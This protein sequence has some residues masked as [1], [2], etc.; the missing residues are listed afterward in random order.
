MRTF[1]IG[2]RI[3][4]AYADYQFSKGKKLGKKGRKK[5][6]TA[7]G[8]KTVVERN[9]RRQHFF[10]ASVVKLKKKARARARARKKHRARRAIRVEK[11]KAV[12]GVNILLSASFSWTPER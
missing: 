4:K 5:H 12:K 11:R 6:Y 7:H 1:R 10:E 3:E 9:Q 2:K 8:K